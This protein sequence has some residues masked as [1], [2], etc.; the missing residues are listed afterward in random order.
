MKYHTFKIFGMKKP[1]S[2]RNTNHVMQISSLQINVQSEHAI[3]EGR[4][5]LTSDANS[6]GLRWMRWFDGKANKLN[7]HGPCNHHFVITEV[8]EYRVILIDGEK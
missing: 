4:A 1:E 8:H 6:Y 5:A 7:L 3:G 2:T